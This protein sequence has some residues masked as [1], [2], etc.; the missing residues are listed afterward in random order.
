MKRPMTLTSGILGIVSHSLILVFGIINM[1]FAFELMAL[2]SNE[3]AGLFVGAIIMVVYALAVSIVGLVFSI[4]T[5][6]AWKKD[7][8][9]FKS[10]KGKIITSIVFAF[11]GIVAAFLVANIIVA[12]LVMFM[13]IA[14]A[15]LAIVDLCLEKKRAGKV[16]EVSTTAAPNASELED[17]IEKLNDMKAQGMISDEEYEELKKNYI[18]E[19]LGM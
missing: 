5:T 3:Y 19:K 11:L 4:L 16:E 8:E 1:I 17:K 13:L 7:T 2:A 14:T 6:K 15:V 10:K 12:I 18:K 9:V